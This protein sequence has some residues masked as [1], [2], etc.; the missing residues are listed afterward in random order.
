MTRM[1]GVELE[2]KPNS[3]PNSP[4]YITIK[5]DQMPVKSTHQSVQVFFLWFIG[6]T[7]LTLALMVLYE[8]CIL[9]SAGVYYGDDCPSD[10]MTCFAST[11]NTSSSEVGIFECVPGNK[12]IF[13]GNTNNAWCYGWVVKR[14]TVSSV[15]NQIGICGGILGVI[16]MLF[17]F[18]FRSVGGKDW[19]MGI[20]WLLFILSCLIIPMMI[21]IAATLHISF[22]VLAYLVATEVIILFLTVLIFKEDGDGEN[23]T[24]SKLPP[25]QM[26]PVS[27]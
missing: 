14:Q 1:L 4:G 21:S 26:I 7:T 18:M 16:G 2:Y 23:D 11:E 12:T 3:K 25:V 5:V 27:N 6:T 8:G 15:I 19:Q 20:W 24:N 10:P 22:S 9:A 17:A 13:P